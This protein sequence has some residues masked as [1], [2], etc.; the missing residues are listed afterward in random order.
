[1][2]IF[3]LHIIINYMFLTYLLFFNKLLTI[4]EQFYI[5][6]HG[7][8]SFHISHS[9][10]LPLSTC[11]SSMVHLVQLINTLLFIKD[12]MLFRFT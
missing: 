11:N 5:C 9:H 1:M 7:P 2:L 3:I 12:H 8:E 10:F 4:L 6:E